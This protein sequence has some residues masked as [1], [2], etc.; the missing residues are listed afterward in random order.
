MTEEEKEQIASKIVDTIEVLTGTES[1][2]EKK[3]KIKET[4]FETK[5]ED[6]LLEES[7]ENDYT[8]KLKAKKKGE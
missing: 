5:E 4:L 3:K 1:K 7:W 6:L 8:T 2:E